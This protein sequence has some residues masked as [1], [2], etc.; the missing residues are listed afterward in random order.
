[1]IDNTLIQ[2]I[3]PGYR[4]PLLGVHGLAHWG[5]V[6]ETGL[7]IAQHNGADP[8]VVE[9]FA[10]FHDSRRENKNVDPGHGRRGAELATLLRDDLQLEVEQLELLTFACIHHTG[11]AT[12]GDVTVR[13]CW[14]ADRLDLWRVGITPR[15]SK[16]CTEPARDSNLQSWAKA[17]SLT[18]YTPPFVTEDWVGN[19][20]T[21]RATAAE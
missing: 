8:R 2:K 10:V 11:G 18:D 9:L 20:L 13:T 3:L 6:L 5:R 17:R 12:E 7:R 15:P 1:M 4:L 19:R 16:L 21:T 14:D